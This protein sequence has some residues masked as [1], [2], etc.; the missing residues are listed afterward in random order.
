MTLK[1]TKKPIE[2]AIAYSIITGACKRGCMSYMQSKGKLK[3]KY[4]LAEILEGTKD[5]YGYSVFEQ[6][7]KENVK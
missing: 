3:K 4:T 1:T 5:A 7:I 6:F 2:W